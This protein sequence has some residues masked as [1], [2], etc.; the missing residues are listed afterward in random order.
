MSHKV[1]LTVFI[2]VVRCS[3]AAKQRSW[4]GPEN[5]FEGSPPTP[6]DAIGLALSDGKLYVFGGYGYEGAYPFLTTHSSLQMCL[7]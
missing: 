3:M 6:R 7:V 5:F 4:L 1:I 2:T